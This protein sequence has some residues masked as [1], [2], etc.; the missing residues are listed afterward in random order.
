MERDRNKRRKPSIEASGELNVEEL[1]AVVERARSGEREALELVVGT[2][3]DRVFG[4]SF[5][6]LGHR[7]DAEDL[8]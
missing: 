6:M 5:R 8:T 1:E 3:Q 2:I 7:S 4:L